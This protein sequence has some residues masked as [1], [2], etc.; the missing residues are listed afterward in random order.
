M[1]FLRL[2]SFPPS[3]II[4]THL[5][6]LHEHGSDGFDGASCSRV[7]AFVLPHF[8]IPEEVAHKQSVFVVQL[9]VSVTGVGEGIVEDFLVTIKT[10][11]PGVVDLNLCVVCFP[12]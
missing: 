11:K 3:V 1:D 4:G 8:H 2:S 10:E 12:R 5:L 9:E 7:R 6:D